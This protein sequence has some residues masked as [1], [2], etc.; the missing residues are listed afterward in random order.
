MSVTE[1]LE[2]F[3][4]AVKGE[5]ATRKIMDAWVQEMWEK[6]SSTAHLGMRPVGWVSIA[7]KQVSCVGCATQEAQRM[8]SPVENMPLWG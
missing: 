5:E 1:T 6:R 3:L 8:V 2:S 4:K 7:R